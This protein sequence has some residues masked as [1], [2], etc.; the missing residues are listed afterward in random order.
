VGD[1]SQARRA[2]TEHVVSPSGG[3]LEAAL[4]VGVA[5]HVGEV[6]PVAIGGTRVAARRSRGRDLALAV[7][8]FH[9]VVERGDGVDVRHR[10]GGPA[11]EFIDEGGLTLPKWPR[12]AY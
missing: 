12:G 4:G 3:D 9:R 11:L 5:P 10:V 2:P 8:V 6:E 1:D 7:E